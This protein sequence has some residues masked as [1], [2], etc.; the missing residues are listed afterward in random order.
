MPT[1]VELLMTTRSAPNRCRA[2]NVDERLNHLHRV[3]SR[4]QQW[5]GGIF[6]FDHRKQLADL[7]RETGRRSLHSA[8]LLLLAAAVGGGGAGRQVSISAAAFWS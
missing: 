8:S 2:R 3:T 1:K 5:P 6:A 4:R 7:A